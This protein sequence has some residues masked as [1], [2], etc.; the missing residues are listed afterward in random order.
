MTTATISAS[1]ST[2]G[3]I[4]AMAPSRKTMSFTYSMSSLGIRAP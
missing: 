1:T 3:A 2:V 4:G